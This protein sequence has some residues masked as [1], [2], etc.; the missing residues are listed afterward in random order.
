M[1]RRFLVLMALLALGGVVVI[2][3]YP[4]V[5]RRPQRGRVSLWRRLG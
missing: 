5:H 2:G 3:G 4:W 1:K